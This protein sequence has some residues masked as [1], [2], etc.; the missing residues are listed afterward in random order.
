MVRSTSGGQRIVLP[1]LTVFI[2]C[3]MLF[4]GVLYALPAEETP[5]TEA[6]ATATEVTPDGAPVAGQGTEP[7]AEEDTAIDVKS[8]LEETLK[9]NKKCLRCHRKERTKLLEDGKEMSLQVHSDAYLNSAHGEVSCVSCHSAIGNR[10]H[11]SKST[12]ITI[13]SERDYSVEMNDSC[14]Q[15]HRQKFAQYK[16]SVHSALVAQG[17]EKA[18]VC[19]SC[20]NPHAPVSMV[21]YQ[22]ET[23]LPCKNCHE[24]IFNAYS[25]SVHGQA[26]I[27]GN[28]I[29]DSHI[30]APICSDCHHS[31]E[32]TALAIGDVLRTTCIACHENATLLH[33]QWLPNAGTHLDIVSCAVCHSP[34]AQRK[35]DLHLYDNVAKAPLAMQEGDAP[36]QEQLQAIAAEGGTGDPLEIWKARGGF[37]KE[38]QPADI[39]LR[40]RMEVMSGVAAHQIASK[41]FAVRTCESCHEPGWRQK[42]NVTVSITQPDGRTQSFEADR[43][44]LGSVNAINS[45]SDFYALG[46]KPSKLLDIM[47]LLSLVAGVAVPIGHFTLGKMI[48]E[49]MARGEK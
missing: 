27:N 45:I 23:G 49:Y 17:S 3:C 12:N 9:K 36:I 13:T 10:K 30:Q 18:P 47:L 11:P 28:T 32:V 1:V 31:H 42:Q 15:C 7:V 35:F 38:G 48:K 5:A 44:A 46:G 21:D 25:V 24:N 34:F 16:G 8:R 29:R 33:N 26:R 22:A 39:S 40:S 37:G 4:S 43:E 20:H 19:S 2:I 6:A 14:R 41:S